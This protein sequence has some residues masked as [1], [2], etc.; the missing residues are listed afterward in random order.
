MQKCTIVNGVRRK[1]VVSTQ[2]TIA[3]IGALLKRRKQYLRHINRADTTVMEHHMRKGIMDLWKHE[4]HGTPEQRALQQRD[5]Q[6]GCGKGKGKD[7]GCGKG[8]GKGTAKGVVTGPNNRAVRR[9]MHSRFAR[10]LQRVGGSKTLVELILFT[11]RVNPTD[12][13]E[14]LST[15]T[16]DASQFAEDEKAEL[17]RA[18]DIARFD[19]RAGRQLSERVNH[20][21]KESRT[22]EFWFSLSPDDQRRVMQYEGDALR[23]T[24]N[25]AILAWGHG[26]ITGPTGATIA[27]GG[28]T[29]G[30]SRRIIDGHS[31]PTLEDLEP[32]LRP[33]C[34]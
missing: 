24:S 10:H 2:E 19:F 23:Q 28:S 15:A 1:T 13:S 27:I 18:A 3:T 17:R 6:K 32:F 8:K 21:F 22:H 33:Q 9:G 29:G 20:E 31:G 25:A 11:G 7:K 30:V 5:S 16:N 34:R 4:Y 12:L 26:T 14:I